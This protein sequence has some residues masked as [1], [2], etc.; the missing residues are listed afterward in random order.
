MAPMAADEISSGQVLRVAHGSVESTVRLMP[1]KTDG[2]ATFPVENGRDPS[3]IRGHQLYEVSPGPSQVRFVAFHQAKGVAQPITHVHEYTADPS[4][5]GVSDL[6]RLS[7][8]VAMSNVINMAPT[9]P[10]Q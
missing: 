3:Y 8:F 7:D 2:D 4:A 1:F 10:E 9:R 6:G 5:L